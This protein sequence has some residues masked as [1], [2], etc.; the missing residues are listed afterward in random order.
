MHLRIVH[1]TGYQY[2]EPVAASY[3]EARL[4]PL[5]QTGQLVTQTR[6]DVTPAP[7]TYGYRDHWGTHVTA[8]EVLD[9]HPSLTVVGTS[10]VHTREDRPVGRGAT[11]DDLDSVADQLSDYLVILERA[12]PPEDL[13]ALVEPLRAAH[14]TPAAAVKAVCDLIHREV[15]Y[16]P[17][18]TGVET[19]AALAW[20]Q[21]SG[22]CQDIAHLAVGCL[23]L[24]RIPARYVSGYLHPDPDP[25][26]G[27]P[28]KG[29]SHAWIEWWDGEWTGF[30][31]TNQLVPGERHVVVATGRNYD[32]VRPVA[33]VYIGGGAESQMFVS[34]EITRLP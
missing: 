2:G 23:R 7:W 9:P 34:V 5:T 26:I 19:D 13:V 32:D 11:W 15:T 31:L 18:T 16:R 29:E 8:F 25:L 21:R 14:A 20:G 4:T 24:L 1:T 3:N 12:A 27:V 28:A 33:G 22:V 10:T 30:D 17:G 6:V